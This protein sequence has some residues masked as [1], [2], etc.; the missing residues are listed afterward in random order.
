MVMGFRDHERERAVAAHP[1]AADVERL[2]RDRLPELR[3]V[4]AA[5]SGSRDASADLVQEAFVRALRSTG[6]FRRPGSLDGWVWRIVVNVAL[7][8]RRER[9]PD[10]GLPGETTAP[11]RDDGRNVRVADAV[12]ALPERQRLVLFLRYYAD[13]DYEAIAQALDISSGTVGA[14]LTAARSALEQAL[15]VKEATS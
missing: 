10:M 6:Q 9:R 13:L 12:R 5:V 1:V 15:A 2:Y 8:Y 7:N 4:A 3:R 14:T 11:A